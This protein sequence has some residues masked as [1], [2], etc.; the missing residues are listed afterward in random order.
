MISKIEGHLPLKDPEWTKF[1][2]RAGG[3]IL[4]I[5]LL[6]LML[7]LLDNGPVSHWPLI[8]TP[9]S[10][11]S[12]LIKIAEVLVFVSSTASAFALMIVDISDR[13]VPLHDLNIAYEALLGPVKALLSVFTSRSLHRFKIA[14]IFVALACT[15]GPFAHNVLT[16][17][18]QTVSSLPVS[19]PIAKD[20][21]ASDLG[22]AI[23]VQDPGVNIKAA[24]LAGLYNSISNIGMM[25]RG[26]IV[27]SR[28]GNATFKPFDTLGV[29]GKCV[30]L[31]PDLVIGNP[32]SAC[33]YALP[34]D[35]PGLCQQGTL[36][37]SSAD[38][39]FRATGSF[40]GY[41]QQ[42][43]NWQFIA[44]ASGSVS[45]AQ[46]ISYAAVHTYKDSLT[47]GVLQETLV[48][49]WYNSSANFTETDPSLSDSEY[50]RL[51]K[52]QT[53]PASVFILRNN[54]VLAIQSFL[55][56][57]H[58]GTI[59]TKDGETLYASNGSPEVIQARSNATTQ[60]LLDRQNTDLH[61][62]LSNAIRLGDAHGSTALGLTL[63]S[64]QHFYVRWLWMIEP[65]LI[66]SM[67]LFILIWAIWLSKRR[68]LT[69][70]RLD[71]LTVLSMALPTADRDQL[72]EH[73]GI[74]S[75]RLVS[76]NTDVT[77]S[78]GLLR[79]KA[80]SSDIDAGKFRWFREMIHGRHGEMLSAPIQRMKG[81]RQRQ[82]SSS[83][84]T[85]VANDRQR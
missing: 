24:T 41:T 53:G 45:A 84:I 81:R 7:A 55:A 62:A 69:R 29:S 20:Y 21:N 37:N 57:Q 38:L 80:V 22:L 27:L 65:A 63:E 72:C 56:D 71:L 25:D 35:G 85:H 59:V 15:M 31:T 4:P 83:T 8:I 64:V 76:R 52:N 34:N 73:F 18:P 9:N 47:N 67:P 46:C 39:T 78:E 40:A 36:W 33:Q 1:I 19:V 68:G 49:E 75:L 44:N 43:L 32:S 58:T 5:G 50:F 13:P 61:V 54:S 82:R 3:A 42:F 60:G 10:V 16:I 66:S 79:V 11:I 17:Y 77:L 23:Q 6:C 26:I 48:S 12:I 28:S 51:S 30:D 70:S 14:V 2:F 74:E